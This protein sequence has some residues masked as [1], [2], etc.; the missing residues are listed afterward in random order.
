M[1]ISFNKLFKGIETEWNSLV[2]DCYIDYFSKK[3]TAYLDNSSPKDPC[4]IALMRFIKYKTD[5]EFYPKKLIESRF[6]NRASLAIGIISNIDITIKVFSGSLPISLL[7]LE[8][9]IPNL[10]IDNKTILPIISL[11]YNIISI[12]YECE[13]Q[14]D[15]TIIYADVNY[16]LISHLSVTCWN[17]NNSFYI[18]RGCAL[19][20]SFPEFTYH[21]LPNM[22]EEQWVRMVRRKKEWLKV[23]EE[24]LVKKTWHPSRFMEWCL[25]INGE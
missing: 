12:E 7:K 4:Q 19:K 9:N 21:D 17:M 14:P 3:D 22:F 18:Q 24:E 23:I 13:Y 2:D 15:I 5:F 16:K 20:N 11:P 10:I 8:K 25:D 1:E 6:L